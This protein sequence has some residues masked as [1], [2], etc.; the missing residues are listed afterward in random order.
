MTGMRYLIMHVDHIDYE[1]LHVLFGPASED[2]LG[3]CRSDLQ[4]IV[5][6]YKELLLF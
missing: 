5:I 1:S 2:K 4:I 3:N 6:I